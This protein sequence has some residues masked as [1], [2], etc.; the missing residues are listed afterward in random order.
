MSLPVEGE[1]QVMTCGCGTNV[2]PSLVVDWAGILA[3]G[4]VLVCT[5]YHVGDGYGG[6]SD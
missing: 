2:Q 4:D 3:E 1:A 5:L 6:S